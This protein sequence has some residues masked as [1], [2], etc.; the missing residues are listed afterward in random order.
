MTS[1]F[2]DSYDENLD[3][4]AEYSPKSD[5][6]KAEVVKTQV[7]RCN[8]LRSKEMKEGYFNHDKIG[9]KV[10]VA[11]SRKEWVSSVRALRLLLVPEII[12]NDAINKQ[13]QKLMKEEEGFANTFGVHPHKVENGNVIVLEDQPKYIPSL[14]EPF[15]IKVVPASVIDSKGDNIQN[16]EG[17]HNY[18]FHGYWDALVDL[19][20]QIFGQLNYLIDQ[21]NY[22]KQGISF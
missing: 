17:I 21:C 20:D 7:L 15:P 10:Y 16:M 1:K 3:D 14:D 9:N 8:D 13:V 4:P 22:F 19:Y 2:D 5:F 11:D 18:K 6:S 12:R